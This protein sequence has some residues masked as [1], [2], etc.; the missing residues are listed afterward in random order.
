MSTNVAAAIKRINTIAQKRETD[1]TQV[2]DIG[3]YC[4]TKTYFAYDISY[5]LAAAPT[6]R[7][8]R[9]LKQPKRFQD[10]TFVQGSG[11]CERSGYDGTDMDNY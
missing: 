3:D 5:L 4:L 8:G 1:P 11:C 7:S 9:I 2:I 6:S 10:E